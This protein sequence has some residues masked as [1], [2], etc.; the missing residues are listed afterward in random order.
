MSDENDIPFPL[1]SGQ[2]ISAFQ[3]TSNVR[4]YY[5]IVRQPSFFDLTYSYEIG[6]GL[7]LSDETITL[8]TGSGA[9]SAFRTNVPGLKQWVTW[10]DNDYLGV[11]WDIVDVKMNSL[12]GTNEPETKYTSPF[13]SVN[14]PKFILNNASG[15][16]T[17]TLSNL[18]STKTIAGTLHIMLYEYQIEKAKGT[19]Q[20]YTD[21][22]YRGT[23]AGVS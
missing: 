18:S 2:Y 11:R 20:Y 1:L 9:L 17:F 10:I 8:G 22:E 12:K 15:N 7:E 21:I 3:D 19:P 23:G 6:P 5:Q 13:G 14:F 4:E 16:V